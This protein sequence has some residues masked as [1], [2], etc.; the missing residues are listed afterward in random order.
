LIAEYLK[1]T[2]RHAINP[3]FYPAVSDRQ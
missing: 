3:F 1:V 2:M